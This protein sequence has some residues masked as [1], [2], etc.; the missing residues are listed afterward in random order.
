MAWATN[1]HAGVV[2]GL[3]GFAFVAATG[4][5]LG[6]V[7]A[8]VG[9]GTLLLAVSQYEST[10]DE[11]GRSDGADDTGRSD[12]TDETERSDRADETERSDGTGETERS[13]DVATVGQWRK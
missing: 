4:G 10:D 12:G 5:T 9:S 3:L 7:V 6:G 13:E 8:L 2:F 11:T 1:R